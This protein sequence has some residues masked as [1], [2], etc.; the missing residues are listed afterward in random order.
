[1]GTMDPMR[2]QRD[3]EA[4][5]VAIGTA[6]GVFAVIMAAAVLGLWLVHSRFDVS[7]GQTDAILGV[8][9]IIAGTLAFASLGRSRR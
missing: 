5:T 6:L 2:T 9:V 7:D 3:R 1:M 8:A 4:Q